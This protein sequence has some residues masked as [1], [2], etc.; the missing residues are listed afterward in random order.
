[1]IQGVSI[2]LEINYLAGKSKKHSLEVG[3]GVNLGIPQFR[4]LFILKF[5]IYFSSVLFKIYQYF[6]RYYFTFD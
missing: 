2:P 4:N 6:Q 3:L 1:M 5:E